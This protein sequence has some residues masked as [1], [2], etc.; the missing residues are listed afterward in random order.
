[1]NKVRLG[2]SDFGALVL[3]IHSVGKRQRFDGCIALRHRSQ[4]DRTRRPQ[5]RH[6]DNGTP[7]G[8]W[9][10]ALASI[11]H[12][13]SRY[14]PYHTKLCFR[15]GSILKPTYSLSSSDPL[16]YITPVVWCIQEHRLAIRPQFNIDRWGGPEAEVQID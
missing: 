2:L 7:K 3:L 16:R 4:A 13:I 9:F 6:W 10:L 12:M 15:C 8:T 14:H 1:M 5:A 11:L